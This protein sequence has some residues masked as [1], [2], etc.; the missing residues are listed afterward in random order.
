MKM[1]IRH[2]DPEKLETLKE[3]PMWIE[4][5]IEK[6]ISLQVYNSREN[7]VLGK[8]TFRKQTLRNGCLAPLSERLFTKG[9]PSSRFLSGTP[10]MQNS[11]QLQTR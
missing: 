11:F 5:T 9:V 3:M 2:N 1:Q 7:M 8:S 4:R 6:E 10:R